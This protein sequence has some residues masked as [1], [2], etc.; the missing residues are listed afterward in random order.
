[1]TQRIEVTFLNNFSCA[2]AYRGLYI[3]TSQT[4]QL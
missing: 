1:M 2:L 4:F 3:G